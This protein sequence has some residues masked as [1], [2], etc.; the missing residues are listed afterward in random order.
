MKALI[1]VEILSLTILMKVLTSCL[2][3]CDDAH[4]ILGQSFTYF[5]QLF[6]S[7]SSSEKSALWAFKRPQLVAT[8]WTRPGFAPLTIQRGFWYSSH[9]NW[10]WLQ[11]PY[12]DLPFM[13]NLFAKMERVRTCD[14]QSKSLPGMFASINNSTDANGEIIGCECFHWSLLRHDLKECRYF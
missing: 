2:P 3:S 11:L 9:E 12:P 10:G 6:T 7:I 1:R 13:K 14:S 8:T 5:L 4:L